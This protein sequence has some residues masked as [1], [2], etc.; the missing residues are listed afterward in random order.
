MILIVSVV[1][2]ALTVITFRPHGT[3]ARLVGVLIILLMLHSIRLFCILFG[4]ITPDDW[5]ITL[6]AG[7]ALI[8][9]VIFATIL[10]LIEREK[11]EAL[12]SARRNETTFR[13]LAEFEKSGREIKERFMSM[14]LHEFKTPLAIIQVA[15]SSLGRR[16]PFGPDDTKRLA[17]IHRAVDD[18][19]TIIERCVQA[20]QLEQGVVPMH[21]R[22]FAL[23]E[24]IDDLMHSVDARER[25][26]LTKPDH[27]LIFS[28]YQYVKVIL[29]NLLNNA[30]KYSPPD[31]LVTLDIAPSA[32]ITGTPETLVCRV[33]NAVGKAGRPDPE[34]VFVRYYRAESARRHV[35]AGLG[36]WL[37]HTVATQL[38]S[39]VRYVAEPDSVC[40]IFTLKQS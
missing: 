2:I 25:I 8:V 30:L 37:A 9:M 19:D 7:R 36:L 21:Q 6:L 10:W 23:D 40:F 16:I 38:E 18:L 4:L 12:L 3:Q 1:C 24:L 28:D 26:T 33:A 20:D 35:G 17:N 22:Q 11:N 31:S 32:S 5:P 29:L 27:C 13:Q 39:T 14:L 34:Q 15:T